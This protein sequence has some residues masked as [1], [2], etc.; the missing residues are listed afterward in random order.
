[1][2]V[3]KAPKDVSKDNMYK[4]AIILFVVGVVLIAAHYLFLQKQQVLTDENW[5]ISVDVSYTAR[6]PESIIRIQSPYESKNVRLVGRRIDYPG[7]SIMPVSRK[8]GT[9]RGIRLRAHKPGTYQ[10]GV[11]FSL[12][13]N[14]ASHFRDINNVL[15]P[16]NRELFLSDNEWQQQGDE[17]LNAQLNKFDIKD[18]EKEKILEDIYKFV[19]K[20]SKYKLPGLRSIQNIVSTKSANNRERAELMVAMVRKAEFPARVVSGIELKDDPAA[21]PVYWVEA[22]I[23]ERWISYYPGLGL[24]ENSTANYIP[25]DKYAADLV[26]VSSE[27][28]PLVADD[29]ALN[30]E[31]VVEKM[32]VSIKGADNNVRQ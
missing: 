25:L 22:Y 29:Y 27:N 28:E 10:V 20:L 15:S 4:F 12:Q 6:Q 9:K 1:M 18:I 8:G 14:Q 17:I 26:S 23:N 5:L 32:P 21:S 3:I 24:K 30:Y 16:A 13:F 7:L 19:N 2:T 11:E 31:I